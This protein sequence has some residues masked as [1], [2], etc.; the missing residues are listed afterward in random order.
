MDVALLQP[1]VSTQECRVRSWSAAQDG[2]CVCCCAH[3]V[4]CITCNMTRVVF[5]LKSTSR[6]SEAHL[7]S[8][9]TNFCSR[10]STKLDRHPMLQHTGEKTRAFSELLKLLCKRCVETSQELRLRPLGHAVYRARESP[11]RFPHGKG[12]GS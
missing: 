10:R 3:D 1:A 7:S 6:S 8:W 4:G 2:S 11:R 12:Q 5:E 9:H